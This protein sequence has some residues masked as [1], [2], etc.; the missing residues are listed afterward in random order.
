M[1]KI[2]KRI[3][4]VYIFFIGIIL[5]GITY[6]LTSPDIGFNLTSANIEINYSDNNNGT[7][8]LTNIKLIPI[9]DSGV[10]NNTDNVIRINFTVSGN[11]PPS[12]AIYDITLNNLVVDNTLLSKY[13]KWKLIKNNTVISEGSLSPDFDTITN[14]RIVL[15]NIQQDLTT[16][17]DS[18]QFILWLSDACQENDITKCIDTENQD[19]L[20]NKNISGKIEVEVYTSNKKA[21]VR[22]TQTEE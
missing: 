7:I 8:D 1:K 21:L 3:I 13:T 17:T 12:N 19:Y 5:L 11:N 18:Y 16:I 6:A 4:I 9:L 2:D 14:G 20:Y 15:T 22:T 10:D